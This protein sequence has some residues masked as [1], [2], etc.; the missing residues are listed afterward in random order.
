MPLRHLIEAARICASSGAAVL[1]AG[2]LGDLGRAAP[3]TEVLFVASEAGER[4]VPAA[5][6]RAE[7]I[8]AVPAAPGTFPDSLPPGWI[9]ER[10]AERPSAPAA[11]RSP[12]GDRDDGVP[13]DIEAEQ[14]YFEVRSLTELPTAAWIFVNELVPKQERGGRSYFP[15]TPRLVERPP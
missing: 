8:G 14:T 13:G 4:E 9:E 5:T 1:P 10:K 3:G 12:F 6:W 11:P 7:L 2:G 15:R